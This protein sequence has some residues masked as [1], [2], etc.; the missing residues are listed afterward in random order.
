MHTSELPASSG[1]PFASLRAVGLWQGMPWLAA[2]AALTCCQQGRANPVSFRNDVMAVL[3]KSGCNQ[4][5]CHGNQN[6]KNGFKL[7]LRGDDPAFDLASLTRDTL[8][9]RTNPLQPAESLLLLKPTGAIPHEG[10]KRFDASSAEY[11]ILWR[12]IHDGSRPDPPMAPVLKEITVTPTEKVVLEPEERLQIRVQA[13]FSDGSARDVTRLAVYE[14]SNQVAAVTADGEVQR[15]EM[16]ETTIQV[17]Y[18]DH[19]VG[20][21]LA[22]VPARPSFRWHELSEANYIDHHLFAKLRTLRMLPSPVCSDSIFLRR[23]YLDVL[24]ILPTSQ[25]A[26]QFLTDT[27]SDKRARLIDALL[28]RSEFAD[29]WALKWSD[30]LRNEEKLLDRKGVQIFHH[31]IRQSIAEGKPLNEF[32]R[33]LVAAR[34]STYSNPPAN[35]YRAIRDPQTR[36][37]A[38]AQV[39]LGIR[40]QCARCHNHPFDH[41]TQNDYHSLAAFFARVDYQILENNRRD[42]FDKHEFDGEQIVLTSRFGEGTNPRTGE[43]LAPHFPGSVTPPLGGGTDR[44]QALADWIARPDNPFFARAQANRIWYHLMGRGIVEPNDDFRASNPP[45]NAPLLDALAQDL[46]T[47]AF[48]L[49]HLIRTIMNSRTYQLSAVPNETNAQD[50]ANFAHAIVRPLQAESLLDA[51]TE[52]TGVP[53]K[54][55]G[56]PLGMRAVQLPGVMPTRRRDLV[57]TEAEQFLRR[58]GKPERLLSCECERSE[59]TTLEQAFQLLAGGVL[60]QLLS[61]PENRIGSLLGRGESNRAIIEELYLASLSRLPTPQELSA[62]CALVE[63]SPNR[64]AALEDLLWGMVNAKEFLLRR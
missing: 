5:A 48:D 33:Q 46:S 2:L 3:S 53:V 28:Q 11:A 43:P 50:E 34:G 27:R 52:V 21:Q 29:Y 55:N 8:G 1:R 9:R 47:H 36:A 18:L 44:L 22:F 13:T 40:L 26:R 59:D 17:R 30:L 57:P 45:I 51:L 49:R 20:V 56:Y 38:V 32:A 64:R 7:S 39:F 58:F 25:E 42:R 14:P 23:A 41:W 35:F 62:A 16:G 10:G 54:F 19:R 15:Q 6:G 24:G 12:W 37:E 60:N 4:G 61:A 31:W 63:R